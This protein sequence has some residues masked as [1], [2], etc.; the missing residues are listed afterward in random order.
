M[1][2]VSLNIN[3]FITF[4]YNNKQ[5]NLFRLIY[6]VSDLIG[7]HSPSTNKDEESEAIENNI[8]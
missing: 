1:L 3:K 8:I 7:S 4:I 6:I 5:I 2:F